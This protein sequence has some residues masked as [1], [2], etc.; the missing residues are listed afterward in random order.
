MNLVGE[1]RWRAI[2]F[3]LKGRSEIMIASITI[4]RDVFLIVKRKK[5]IFAQSEEFVRYFRTILE[6]KC[7]NNLLLVSIGY[8]CFEDIF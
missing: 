1:I 3:H 8:F 5:Y 7:A 4:F 2:V 6:K